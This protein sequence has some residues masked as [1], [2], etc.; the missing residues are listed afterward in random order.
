MAVSFLLVLVVSL[1]FLSVGSGGVKL[2]RRQQICAGSCAAWIAVQDC[3]DLSC[4]CAIVDA[5]DRSLDTCGS[6]LILNGD[7]TDALSIAA[8]PG[9]CNTPT[10]CATASACQSVENAYKECS[11]DSACF[12]SAALPVLPACASCYNNVNI[13][14][15]N[16]LSADYSTC[17]TEF[18]GSSETSPSPATTPTAPQVAPTVTP[19][20][21]S[22]TTPQVAPTVAPTTESPTTPQVAPTVAPTTESPT[23]PQVA[24]TVAPTESTVSRAPTSNASKV[25]LVNLLISIVSF[26]GLVAILY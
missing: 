16:L 22:P 6:C 5:D 2:D 10:G 4:V 24:P 15:A 21:E 12:C 18:Y 17:S 26:V 14:Q 19:T 25:G 3:P 8:L 23:T 13:T 11:T 7:E 1:T 9:Q 20:T